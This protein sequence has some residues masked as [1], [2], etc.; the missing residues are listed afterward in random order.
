MTGDA[1][2]RLKQLLTGDSRSG[3]ARIA[4]QPVIKLARLHHDHRANHS[5]VIH[6]AVLSTEQVIRSG[7]GRFKP[8]RRVLAGHDVSFHA[9]RRNEEVVNH[10]FGGHDQLDLLSNRHVQLI[11]LALASRMLNL[12]HP[13]FANDVDLNCILRRR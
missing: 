8:L 2:K 11:D 5:R 1:T 7:L 6:S 4:A 9:K 12:P 13:L 3:V 10:V